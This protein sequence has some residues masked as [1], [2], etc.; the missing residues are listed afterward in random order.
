MITFGGGETLEAHHWPLCLHWSRRVAECCVSQTAPSWHAFCST[1]DGME[2]SSWH[3]A[4]G[5]SHANID[6]QPLM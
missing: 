1:R 2:C 4:P 5:H 3:P 6:P